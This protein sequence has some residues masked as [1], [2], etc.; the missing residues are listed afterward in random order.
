MDASVSRLKSVEGQR[1]YWKFPKI[2]EVNESLRIF[3]EEMGVISYESYQSVMN[4]VQVG[5]GISRYM[6]A[7]GRVH[8]IRS[9]KPQ[10]VVFESTSTNSGVFFFHLLPWKLRAFINF[11][12][13]DLLYFRTF[14]LQYFHSTFLD[15]SIYFNGSVWKLPTAFIKTSIYSIAKER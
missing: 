2:V 12:S 3:V 9:W 7:R 8:R 4:L 14:H 10:L 11:Y 1:S 13:L 5:G 15:A 6:E